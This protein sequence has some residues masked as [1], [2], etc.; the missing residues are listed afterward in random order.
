MSEADL[1][2]GVLALCAELHIVA[3]HS[4]DTKRDTVKGWPDLVLIGP[5]DVAFAELK[6][7]SGQPSSEQTKL[8]YKIRSTGHAWM[9]WTPREWKSG[10][11]R[12]ILES[13]LQEPPVHPCIDSCPYAGE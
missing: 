13:M 5:H 7:M 12:A 6:G 11:I 8:K 2:R 9:L 10:E 1:L 4:F 3:F